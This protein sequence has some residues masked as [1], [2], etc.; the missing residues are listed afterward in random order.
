[1][2]SARIDIFFSCSFQEE[3][4]EVNDFFLAI[5]S[6]LDIKCINVDGAYTSVPPD[7]A[8]KQI[9]D[10]QG[11]IAIATKRNKLDSGE[12][13]MPSAV[14]EELSMA[15][16]KDTQILL[17]VEDGVSIDG[18]KSNYGTYMT[19]TRENICQNE[20]LE[21]IIRSTH[22]LKLEIISPNDLMYDQD[23]PEVM[24]DYVKQL[25]ELRKE[26]TG[27]TWSYS[28][29]K[30]L[31]FL[32]A[33]KRHLPVTFWAAVPAIIPDGESDI[34]TEIK[35]E[36]HSRDLSLNIETVKETPD[37]T[38]SLI[39]IE[40]HPDKGDFIEYSA[41]VK[42]KYFNPVYYEDISANGENVSIDINGVTYHCMD[43]L[44]PIQRT[45]KMFLEFRFPRGFGI[46][47]ENIVFFVGSYTDEVDYL[48]GSEMTR[49][50]I[51]VNEIGG[52]L[53]LRMEIDSPLLRHMYGFAWNPPHKA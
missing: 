8:R 41:F 29:T 32:S 38:K 42:S 37:C 23:T 39:K 31:Q 18:M 47:N 19:F 34:H 17:F 46:K 35:L 45:K 43:G 53:T 40:P 9:D 10:A 13:A 4:R 25:F 11:L 36:S 21:K 7:V 24:A 52:N 20:I 1:M 5:C 15:Y 22:T 14:Q 26:G 44:I 3:D 48:V 2:K 16:G 33:F 30:K 50:N 49:A 51:D 6:A 28:I 12:Y 27:Y